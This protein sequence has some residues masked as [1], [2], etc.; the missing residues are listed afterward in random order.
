M[1][2][3]YREPQLNIDQKLA[4]E[5]EAT[6]PR[7]AAVLVGAQYVSPGF[8]SKF[9]KQ[10]FD[11]DGNTLPLSFTDGETV[12]TV[13]EDELILKLD[14][15]SVKLFVENAE[16]SVIFASE[17][18]Y[19]NGMQVIAGTSPNTV[20]TEEVLRAADTCDLYPRF[21]NRSV[22]VGDIAYISNSETSGTT[23]R[24]KVKG[25]IGAPIS[26]TYG[27]DSEATN[28]EIGNGAG[29]PALSA[30]SDGDVFEPISPVTYDLASAVTLEDAGTDTQAVNINGLS[31]NY[32]G[33][34]KAGVR[35]SLRVLTFNNVAGTGT[36][37]I[38]STDG[39]ISGA[40]TFSRA[41]DV[42]T[43]NLSGTATLHGIASVT[44]TSTTP[45]TPADLIP[46]QV[47]AFTILSNYAQLTDSE[48]AVVTMAGYTGESD[49]TFYVKVLTGNDANTEG[50]AIVKVY[51]ARG[52]FTPFNVTIPYGDTGTISI[53][54]GSGLS[55]SI[56]TENLYEVAQ[57]GL[58][59]ND[60][61]FVSAKA[62]RVSSTNFV[63]LILDGPAAISG[64][65]V[66][67]KLRA[68]ATGE[69]STDNQISSE[70]MSL[71]EA[72]TEVNYVSGLT[73]KIAERDLEDQFE[74]LID[75]VGKVYIDWRAA[76]VPSASEKVIGVYSDADLAQFGSAHV[77]N[78]LAF[79]AKIA[80][81]ASEASGFFVLRTSGQSAAEFTSALEKLENSDVY[82]AIACISDNPEAFFVTVDHA[83]EMSLKT[84]K[85]FRKVYFGVD[86]PGEF[87][88]ADKDIDGQDLAATVTTYSGSNRYVAFEN[89][90]LNLIQ[91]DVAVGDILIID[92]NRLVIEQIVSENEVLITEASAPSLPISPAL[93]VVIK[94]ADTPQNQVYYVTQI[95]ETVA[96]RRGSLIW[97]DKPVGFDGVQ[98]NELLVPVKFAAA[99]VAA[100]RAITPPQLGLT[101][102]EISLF[103]ECPN[104]Y[105]K[106][107]RSLLNEAAANGV[108][109]ITQEHEAGAVFVRHQLTTEVD[110]GYLYYEDSVTTNVDNLSFQFKDIL[111]KYVGKK[112]VTP[113]TLSLI[114]HEVFLV[115]DAARSTTFADIQVGPQILEFYDENN[116]VGKVTV[117]PHPT[118][119]DR[120][121]VKV[122]V[123]IPLP[124]NILEVEIEAISEV[125]TITE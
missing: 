125:V 108:M 91:T 16:Y 95:A 51:D 89:P 97:C 96:N 71:N 61:F 2:L 85:N 124:L 7:Q 67:M 81:D 99:E 59:K 104:M 120:V 5:V 8:E 17:G 50:D 122:K 107:T 20:I 72:G 38:T 83:D 34:L 45:G 4:T 103:K 35:L 32:A 49:N 101:R 117:K 18:D 1:I 44:A 113:T 6:L 112:N 11:E 106:F 90:N 105:T 33:A 3:N 9:D 94:K 82:Y 86:S 121:L 58:R 21:G 123:T 10:T 70:F 78:D 53:P 74:P 118:F 55:L 114:S 54:L 27:S 100:L 92:N 109:I 63:G 80:R 110:K 119:K 60:I 40:G 65:P 30:S 62:A 42:I 64:S 31:V 75:G 19:A 37:S 39:V 79:A 24:R 77:N 73:W 13:D 57:E 115:L 98:P 14:S 26:A 52:S 48:I 43:F 84:V 116:V 41:G 76:K 66:A 36:M 25:F 47:F 69:I 22:K 12:N 68:V 29:N 15:A 88:F 28:G 93:P 102:Q 46:G 87:E 23:V 111:D 56:N